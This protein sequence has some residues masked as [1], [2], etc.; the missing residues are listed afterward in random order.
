MQTPRNI[1]D[2]DVAK[3][4]AHP[5]RVRLLAMLEERVASPSEMAKHLDADLGVVAYHVRRLAAVGLV[6]MVRTRQRRGAIEHYYKAVPHTTIT[7]DAWADVPSLVKAA[8]VSATLQ[9]V[10][11]HVNAAASNAG[12]DRGDAHLSRTPLTL[13]ARGWSELAT[14]MDKLLQDAEKIAAASRQRLERHQHDG[15]IN[16]TAVLMLFEQAPTPVVD[17]TAASPKRRTTRRRTTAR[18]S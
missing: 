2:P 6:E 11:S 4:L 12:F 16:G 5:L 15:A 1:V 3:A 17:A 8:M 7:S 14:K 10:S 13:D 18:K 9:E